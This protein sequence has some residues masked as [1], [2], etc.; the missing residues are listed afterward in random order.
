M[1]VTIGTTRISVACILGILTLVCA[2]TA[3]ELPQTPP[4]QA[5]ITIDADAPTRTYDRMIFGGFLEH[6]DNQI[7]GGVFD[8]GSPLADA[9]GFRTD[10]IAALKELKMPVIRWPG[11]CFVDAYRW[12][13]GV[14]KNREPYGDYR[15]GVIE[16]NTFGTDEFVE[17]CRRIGAEPYICF[18][19]M[20]SPQENLDWVAYCNATEG[21]FAE[22]R[23]TNGNPE[24][25]N[26]KFWS[27]GNERYDK[28]YIDRVRDTAKEMRRLYP[29]L[30]IMCAGAQDDMKEVH[31][32]LMEQAGEYLDYVSIHSYALDR[33]NELPRYDYLTAISRSEKPEAFIT[34][35]TRSLREKDPAGRI[36]IAYDEWNLRA[37]QHPGFPR[38]EVKGYDA[39]EV[40]ELVAKR[41][42]QNDLPDQYT[43]ADALF[44]AS[45]L[46]ACLRHSD[47][48]T[49]ANIAPLVNTRGPL[50][51]HPE[52][53]VKR[54][55]FHALSMYS[56]LL[57][58][59]VSTAHVESGQLEGTRVATVDAIATVDETGKQWSIALINRHPSKAVRCTLDMKGVPLDGTFKATVLTGDS[60]DAYNDI[61]RP[62]RVVPKET[63]LIIKK[64]ITVLPPLSL[65]IL[66]IAS[67]KRPLQIESSHKP[68]KA[69]QQNR[70]QNL[71]AAHTNPLPRLESKF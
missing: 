2:A 46:N 45:F 14:G 53:L 34:N 49:M 58:P 12:Q 50:F 31:D 28:A 36:K 25:F 35:I 64:G 8:P 54:T 26:V 62:D 27:V 7:Y 40:R 55:H 21:T 18:N 68:N 29:S 37:W 9:V 16:P 3:N 61:K 33:G 57:Q 48:V 24:P 32:Y 43:M 52:G 10:V 6:F 11:G 20:T 60:P 30:K 5:T 67:G 70:D 23:K 41:R 1:K 15:W 19:G 69:L 38:G 51:V 56:N 13:K 63:E 39:P 44:T 4:H 47:T 59:H 42:A 17:F 71:K 22:M 65:T 66:N